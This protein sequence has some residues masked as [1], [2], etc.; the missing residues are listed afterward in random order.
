METYP[1]RQDMLD[2]ILK[3]AHLACEQELPDSG[4]EEMLYRLQSV[5]LSG[6]RPTD[7]ET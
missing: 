5:D 2:K 7:G 1:D 6:M 3:L 4:A